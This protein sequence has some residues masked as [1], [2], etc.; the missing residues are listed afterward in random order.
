VNDKI[1]DLEQ[2]RTP[3]DFARKENKL[4]SLR[5]RFR[6]ARKDDKPAPKGRGRRRSRK[7]KK[8]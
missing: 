1:I 5:N 2:A 3:H 8:R 4:K 7:P 6:T